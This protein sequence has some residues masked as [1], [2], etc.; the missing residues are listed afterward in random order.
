[1]NKLFCK[2]FDDIEYTVYDDRP[3]FK[4]IEVKQEHTNIVLES[5][6]ENLIHQ[7]ADGILIK[8]KELGHK[9]LA[10]KTA[11]C[12]PVAFISQDFLALVHA[13]WK[14]LQQ[15]ILLAPE[16]KDISWKKIIIGPSICEYEVQPDFK[17]NFP[18]N[19]HFFEENGHLYFNL[20]KEAASQLKQYS[21]DIEIV[22]VCTLK[23]TA[24]NS[25]RRDKTP[26][27]NW[28]ILKIK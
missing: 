10:I 16:L 12:L 3:N 11:D 26:K 21:T 8:P 27:R 24:Y 17:N 28:N 22:D 6:G 23:N 13:G 19:P 1:M 4:V 9:A 25:Y 20:Q 5:Q 7:V 15:K 14:G 2:V 18:G